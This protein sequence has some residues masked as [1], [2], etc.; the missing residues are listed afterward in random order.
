MAAGIEL[1]LDRPVPREV[2]ADG[3]KP[4]EEGA[5]LARHFEVLSLKSS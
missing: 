2:L 4:F 1:A 3:V 5:V